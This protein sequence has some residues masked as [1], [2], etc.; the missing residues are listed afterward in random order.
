[1][2]SPSTHPGVFEPRKKEEW[3]DYVLAT[4]PRLLTLP[5]WQEYVEM[6]EI[7]RYRFN[8]DRDAQHSALVLAWTPRLNH[9][10]EQINVRLR[11]NIKAQGAKQCMLI[12]GPGTV[13][14]ST[15]VKM[16]ARKYELMLR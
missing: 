14:K 8:N 13:G 11:A 3:R 10:E 6:D 15:M 4:D 2:D 9:F 5:S 1:M 16:V 7:A 12:D